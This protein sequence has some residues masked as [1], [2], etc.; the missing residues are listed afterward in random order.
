[1]KTRKAQILALSLLASLL[2]VTGCSDNGSVE[3]QDPTA[4]VEATNMTLEDVDERLLMTGY[5][6]TEGR[7]CMPNQGQQAG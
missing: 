5:L 7:R 2:M 3:P 4:Q 6:R 1:M